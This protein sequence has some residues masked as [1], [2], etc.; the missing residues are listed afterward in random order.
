MSDDKKLVVFCIP[1]VKRPH[2]ACLDALEACLP[3]IEEHGWEH[4]FVNEIGN[5][6]ISCARAMML[7]KALDVMPPAIV[8]IDHDIS[9]KPEDMLA[10]LETPGE[11][12]C[13]TYR[14]KTPDKVEY[15]GQL[16]P[17]FHGDPALAPGCDVAQCTAEDP[18]KYIRL[19]A[20]SV[21]AG[22]LKI[23]PIAIH[24]FMK[25]YPHLVYG[26]AW[27][28]YVDL[29]N[30]G[31]H[32]GVWWGEDY[33][34]CRNWRDCGGQI[35]LIPNLDLSHWSG[36][37]EFPGNFHRYLREQPGGDLHQGDSDAGYQ[38]E[39]CGIRGRAA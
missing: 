3:L 39:R 6:Y 11:V 9:W 7:R 21:P 17:G 14:F 22:F 29:F 35:I 13:G 31:A 24:K 2:Q 25:A 33:A 10:L 4:K 19:L 15:M 30:H 26:D 34:F 28:P 12:V 18:D 38:S 27:R 20:H 8:F 32:E 36:D 16:M 37:I 1:T 23:T 5:P